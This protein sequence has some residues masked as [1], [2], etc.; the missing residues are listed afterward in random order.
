MWRAWRRIRRRR[1]RDGGNETAG[2]IFA[3]SLIPIPGI[4]LVVTQTVV[5]KTL[6][7]TIVRTYAPQRVVLFGSQA[8]GTANAGS[9]LD[10]LVVLDDDVPPEN[11]SW[12][13]QYKARGS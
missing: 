5:P 2:S 3:G 6:I 9:D 12:R 11:L 10:L 4:D 13:H 8:H 7:D 1:G